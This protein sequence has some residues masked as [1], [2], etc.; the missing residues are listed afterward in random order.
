[1]K[2]FNHIDTLEDL[3]SE[4]RR[5]AMENH[6]DRGGNVEAMQAINAEFELAFLVM[7]KKGMKSSSFWAGFEPNDSASS[8]RRKFY[9]ENGWAGSRYNPEIRLRDIAPIVRGYVKDVYPSWKFSVVQGHS[10]WV[11]AL[12]VYLMEAPCEIFT[13]EGVHRDAWNEEK[14]ETFKKIADSGYLQNWGC[15]YE[16][17]TARAKAVLTDVQELVES[18]RYNDS[19]AR[20]DYFDTN[21]YAHYYI[22]K[23]DRPLKIVQKR[24]RI[25]TSQGPSG[26][27]RIVG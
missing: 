2:Y 12:Y 3:K 24:E 5:L 9:T 18:Y 27:K 4:F 17:M 14:Y 26:A 6:P 7:K 21:F 22:G 19:D 8:F 16:W 1:M 10:A 11:S 15:R 25:Q 13:D 20:Y 23:F